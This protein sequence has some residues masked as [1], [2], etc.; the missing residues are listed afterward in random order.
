MSDILVQL[1]VG[2]VFAILIIREV[3]GFVKSHKPKNTNG[4]TFHVTRQEFE[5][6]K[7]SVQ[8]RDACGEIVKRIDGNFVALEKRDEERMANAKQRFDSID[9]S[10]GEVKTMIGDIDR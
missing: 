4:K 2:G 1:G 10:I 3:F 8:Y 7:D 6:H 9:S 5:K